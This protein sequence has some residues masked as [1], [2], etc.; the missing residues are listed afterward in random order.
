MFSGLL[1]F[2]LSILAVIFV[3]YA[4][5]TL[6][7]GTGG[8]GY[9]VGAGGAGAA[10]GISA[11]GRGKPWTRATWLPFVQLTVGGVA[12]VLMSQCRNV[13]LVV[14]LVVVLGG[15]AA[16]IMIHIDAKLQE[17]VE[18][19]RRGAVFAAR[20]MLTSLTMIVAFW[21]QIQTALFRDTPAATVLLWLG[22]GSIAATALMAITLVGSERL[23]GGT[24]AA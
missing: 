11:F 2:L 10:L 9:L 22:I 24:R 20:G 18:D 16:T 17:Q 23:T 5:K 6:Q 19:Q 15:V 12:M 14:P 7:L 4:F 13:W 1:A 21:L 8:F 3:G